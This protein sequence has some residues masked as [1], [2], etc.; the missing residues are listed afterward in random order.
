M[1]GGVRGLVGYLFSHVQSVYVVFLVAF[2]SH[3]KE[4]P[5]GNKHFAHLT[6]RHDTCFSEAFRFYQKAYAYSVFY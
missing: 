5:E 4:L 2:A 6:R 3:G 1:E